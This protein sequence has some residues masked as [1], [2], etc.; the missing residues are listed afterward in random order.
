MM[1]SAATRQ[2]M[3]LSARRGILAGCDVQKSPKSE[4]TGN[5]KMEW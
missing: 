2:I 5:E 4:K 3:L 1:S